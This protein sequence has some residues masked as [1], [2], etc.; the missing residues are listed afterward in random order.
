MEEKVDTWGTQMIRLAPVFRILAE[1]R[2]RLS[3]IQEVILALGL[4]CY[5][6]L[7]GYGLLIIGYYAYEAVT[8]FSANS[9]FLLLSP[10]VF[11]AGFVV[12]IIFG[13]VYPL[14]ILHGN[15]LAQTI[16]MIVAFAGLKLPHQIFKVI[17]PDI[18]A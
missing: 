11:I 12:F 9:L 18:F 5:T 7:L 3:Y 2:K 17:L 15:E 10:F 6:W 14:G 13:L 1:K 4:G 16:Y 8:L